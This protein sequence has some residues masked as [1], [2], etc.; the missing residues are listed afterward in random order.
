MIDP[1]V[2]QA[3]VDG[4]APPDERILL[5]DS[6]DN[7]LSRSIAAHSCVKVQAI[8]NT[9]HLCGARPFDHESL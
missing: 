2:A 1:P 7:T 6:P 8:D 9:G 3:R 5:M 4:S